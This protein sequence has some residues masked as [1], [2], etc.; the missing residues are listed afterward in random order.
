MESTGNGGRWSVRKQARKEGGGGGTGAEG[1]KPTRIVVDCQ[2]VLGSVGISTDGVEHY[3]YC[4]IRRDA[5]PTI[6]ASR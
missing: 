2:L 3:Y 4:F 6:I 5:D 1:S